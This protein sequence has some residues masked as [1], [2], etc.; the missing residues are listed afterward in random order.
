MLLYMVRQYKVA[1]H[2]RGKRSSF[3]HIQELYFKMF[4]LGGTR[5]GQLMSHV[6][7]TDVKVN[8]TQHFNL[9][10]VE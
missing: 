8:V 6:T 10:Y 4:S 9:F 3:D 1:G 7:F 2:R 5:P